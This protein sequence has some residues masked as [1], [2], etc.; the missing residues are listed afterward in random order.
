MMVRQLNLARRPVKRGSGCTLGF[1]VC[2]WWCGIVCESARS[3]LGQRLGDV[4]MLRWPIAHPRAAREARREK[5]A[6]RVRESVPDR[7]L[8][9]QVLYA[10]PAVHFVFR[11]SLLSERRQAA[12]E[13]PIGQPASAA[14][15]LAAAADAA[16][17]GRDEPDHR[18]TGGAPTEGKGGEMGAC[19][20][21]FESIPVLLLV[22]CSS[23]CRLARA[24]R[25][26]R[27]NRS[28]RDHATPTHRPDP[29]RSHTHEGTRLAECVRERGRWGAIRCLARCGVSPI[30]SLK[31]AER[32]AKRWLLAFEELRRHPPL[33]IHHRLTYRAHL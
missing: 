31:R 24:E 11:A 12:G 26:R 17:R 15:R 21:S 5:G 28:P 29:A 8:C 6:T 13:L 16:D 7:T 3:G 10:R 14:P 18:R 23:G 4:A 25:L 30:D 2:E 33:L 27:K 20:R 9:H 1:I 32:Q 19:C 22:L